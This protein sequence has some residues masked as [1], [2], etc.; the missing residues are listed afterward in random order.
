MNKSQ[1]KENDLMPL[2]YKE[3]CKKRGKEKKMKKDNK[4]NKNSDNNQSTVI[5]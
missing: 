2:T 3:I 4:R 5:L 1:T